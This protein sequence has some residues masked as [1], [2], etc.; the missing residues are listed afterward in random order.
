VLAGAPN[1]RAV[2]HYWTEYMR[3]VEPLYA[4]LGVLAQDLL[5]NGLM[6]TYFTKPGVGVVR[7]LADIH[8]TV[9][10]TGML[11]LDCGTLARDFRESYRQHAKEAIFADRQ[12]AEAGLARLTREATGPRSAHILAKIRWE[13]FPPTQPTANVARISGIYVPAGASQY[14][15]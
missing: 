11:L 7:D 10:E 14:P 12:T 1:G 2:E 5:R 3:R 6:H 9:D 8:L 4:E 13:L 15:G